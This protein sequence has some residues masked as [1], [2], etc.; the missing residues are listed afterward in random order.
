MTPQPHLLKKWSHLFNLFLL[1]NDC[2]VPVKQWEMC[3]FLHQTASEETF[4]TSLLLFKTKTVLCCSVSLCLIT[5]LM[6]FLIL[7]GFADQS[8]LFLPTGKS[9]IRRNLSSLVDICSLSWLSRGPYTLLHLENSSKC[10][11]D[12]EAPIKRHV[13][14]SQTGLHGPLQGLIEASE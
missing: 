4:A 11:A 10:S 6:S 2:Q 8:S 5:P 3:M 12:E 7:G 1:K 14:D 9:R 13:C